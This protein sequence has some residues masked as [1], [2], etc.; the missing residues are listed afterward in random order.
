MKFSLVSL[1]FFSIFLSGCAQYDLG[2]YFED[3]Q[4]EFYGTVTVSI[5]TGTVKAATLDG[6]ITC[7]GTS[8]VTEQPSGYTTIGGK[9]Q[10]KVSCSDG[11]KFVADFLQ[12]R[13]SGGYGQGIDNL[14]NVV[15]IF[16]DTNR[17]TVEANIAKSKL[18]S[19]L[20]QPSASQPTS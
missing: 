9:G 7:E 15:R 16:Y 6:T 10:A 8:V 17:S 11:R 18:N 1:A 19:V 13:E 12:V 20:E 3:N 4:Q 2:G 5:D 14:G